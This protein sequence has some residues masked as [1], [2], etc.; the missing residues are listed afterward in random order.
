MVRIRRSAVPRI[1][2]AIAFAGAL[3]LLPTNVSRRDDRWLHFFAE[4][5]SSNHLNCLL[6]RQRFPAVT[7]P[8]GDMNVAFTMV[9]HKD[10]LQI[11]RLLRMIYRV[12]NYY[13]IHLDARSPPTFR[14]AMNGV[15]SCF[16]S[17]VELVPI[18]KRVA[19]E[20]GDESV[21]RPQLICA[22]QALQRDDTWHYLVNKSF[23]VGQEFPLKTNLELVAALKALNG[24]NL[25][26]AFPIKRFQDWVGNRTLPLNAT[27]YKGTV[28]GAFRRDFLNE[29]VRGR[30]MAPIRETLLQHKVFEH[31]DELFFSTLA[32]NPHLRLPG[33]CLVAPPP[34]SEV[35]LG[36]PAKFVVWRDYDIACPTKY[37]RF[38][39]ILG[40]PHLSLLRSVPH[41]FANKFHADYHREAYDRMEE[42]YFEKLS[43]ELASGSYA[44]NSFD[45]TFYANR[46]CSR[47]HL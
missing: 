33:S 31:P 42:W 15:A 17:N 6:F 18:E 7:R 38:V 21:L 26:E 32:Y 40:A 25:I 8:D 19:V 36:F 1:C 23:K 24:S 44:K 20:W 27:W 41:L 39:C 22:E 43:K 10:V 9:V 47:H 5:S 34:L 12:N 4:I 46:T 45:I 3:F 30:A 35:N 14:N 37:V 28:Y 11:A 16:G 2:I 13:C 29:A